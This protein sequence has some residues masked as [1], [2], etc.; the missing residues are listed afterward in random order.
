MRKFLKSKTLKILVCCTLIFTFVFSFLSVSAIESNGATLTIL[1]N[2]NLYIPGYPGSQVYGNITNSSTYSSISF[3]SS[4]DY[5][6]G[7][8]VFKFSSPNPYGKIRI[9]IESEYDS[10]LGSSISPN[11]TWQG[12]YVNSQKDTNFS[13]GHIDATLV[14]IQYEGLIPE[15]FDVVTFYNTVNPLSLYMVATFEFTPIDKGAQDIIDNQNANT[16]KVINSLGGSADYNA[17]SDGD[18]NNLDELESSL[19][20][21]N[22]DAAESNRLD[23]NDSVIGSVQ[24]LTSSFGA[25]TALFQDIT[26]GTI[27]DISILIYFSIFIGLVP[28][29]VGLSVQGLRARDRS[30]KLKSRKGKKGD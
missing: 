25:V 21:D 14:E 9:L 11:A 5:Y 1:D 20:N 17:P 22:K 29:I 13:Y 4:N 12:V 2:S 6:E 23:I 18:L 26:L 30:D 19:I 27:P 24:R 10:D 3:Q 7:H 16:D 28:L 15:I 8:F